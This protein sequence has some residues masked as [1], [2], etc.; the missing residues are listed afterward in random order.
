M[1][2]ENLKVPDLDLVRIRSIEEYRKYVPRIRSRTMIESRIGK[3]NADKDRWFQIGF[4]QLCGRDTKFSM[5]WENSKNDLPNYRE[6]LTC[7]YCKLTNRQRFMFNLL[8]KQ[9]T[10]DA[11]SVFMYE[12]ATYAFAYTKRSFNFNLIGSEFR[13]YDKKPGEVIDG[14]RHEDAMSLSFPED[15]FDIMVSNDG[16]EHVPDIRR[17]LSEAYRVLRGGGGGS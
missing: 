1:N 6:H 15:S 4:C 17:T 5:C 8:K 9:Q 10:G 12:A 3:E 14:I 2:Y 11:K 13:G 16:F 7:E